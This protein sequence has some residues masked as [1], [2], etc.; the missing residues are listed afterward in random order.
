VPATDAAI[1]VFANSFFIYV[2]SWFGE[3]IALLKL[4]GCCKNINYLG[5]DHP[6]TRPG[7]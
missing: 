2:S 1:R 4:P 5:T 3:F 6:D 7:H